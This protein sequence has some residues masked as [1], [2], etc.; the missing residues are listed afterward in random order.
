MVFD[1]K[2]WADGELITAADL[3]RVEQA[4]G[5]H[6]H[7]ADSITDLQAAMDADAAAAAAAYEQEVA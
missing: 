3:N 1:P 7:T 6:T 2:T 4:L 5:A